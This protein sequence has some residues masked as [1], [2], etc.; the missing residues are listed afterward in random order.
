MRFAGH[1]RDFMGHPEVE[2]DDYL[3]YMHARH[4][5]PN[6]GRFLSVDPTWDS[7]HLSMPQSW[8][9]YSYVVNNPVNLT[10]P[11]GRWWDP[12]GLVSRRFKR[13]QNATI[14]TVAKITADYVVEDGDT[15]LF[16]AGY[17]PEVSDKPDL[18]KPA[19]TGA[20]VTAGGGIVGAP[21]GPKTGSSGGPGSGKNFSEKTKNEVRAESN[22]TCVFCGTET[23]R[24]PGPNQSNIDHAEAKA[25]GGNNTLPNAQNTCRTC[26]L[27]KAVVN[28]GVS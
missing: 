21:G 18:E 13:I 6:L 14:G 17:D 3:D 25:R 22:N 2:S 24:T 4:Y 27:K 1:W 11:D 15:P 19:V 26:N 7:A 16:E 10:D 5:D 9:R 20:V 12:R 28:T 23:T 8:N